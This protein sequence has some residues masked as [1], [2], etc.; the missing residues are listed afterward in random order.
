MAKQNKTEKAVSAPQKTLAD[1]SVEA[2]KAMAYDCLAEMERLQGVLR[3]VNAEIAKKAQKKP[4][5]DVIQ[6]K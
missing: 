3:A 5:G 1:L 4:I 2:L 6:G